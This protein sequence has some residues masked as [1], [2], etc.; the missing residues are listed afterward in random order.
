[1]SAGD[2]GRYVGDLARNPANAANKVALDIGRLANDQAGGIEQRVA[3]VLDRVNPETQVA[4]AL[5]RLIPFGSP[6]PE[7]SPPGR[8]P[9]PA[10]QMEGIGSQVA[11]AL[12]RLNP[13]AAPAPEASPRLAERGIGAVAKYA[14]NPEA[15]P[16]D[17][18]AQ[19]KRAFAEA[20]REVGPGQETILPDHH[21]PHHEQ[22]RGRYQ[23]RTWS[24]PWPTTR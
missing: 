3:N 11:N 10:D 5:D 18:A 23:L 15:L 14:V 6:A 7:A 8:D 24:T 20:L 4:N 17:L 12:S 1:M 22:L 19:L 16:L 21:H 9:G 2:I 13:F